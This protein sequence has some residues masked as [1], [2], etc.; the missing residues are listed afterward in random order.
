MRTRLYI[1]AAALLALA[2]CDRGWEAPELA[3]P[4]YDGPAANITIAELKTKYAATTEKTPSLIEVD[5]VVRAVVTAN[6]KSGNI[7]KQLYVSDASASINIGVDQNSMCTKFYV[8]QEVFVNL[9]GLSVVNYGGELQIG[10]TGTNA[11]RI[12]WEIFNERTSLNGWPIENNVVPMTIELGKQTDGMVNA[13]VRIEGVTF[14]NGGKNNFTD[15]ASTTNETLKDAAGNTVIV[16]TSN[17]ADFAAD[18][19]PSGTGTVAGILGRHRGTWQIVL[20]S[21]SDVIGFNAR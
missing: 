20:R 16:R 7:F 15:G 17:Y 1:A 19:L 21:K 3:E 4:K 12:P 5:Y 9:H 18:K 11:N 6:D 10:Y 13:L 2:S 14:E 8:G